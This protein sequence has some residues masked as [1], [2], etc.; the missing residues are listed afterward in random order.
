M[1]IIFTNCEYEADTIEKPQPAAENI[2]DWYKEA[3]SYLGAPRV[4][5][6]TGD[7]TATVKKCMPL[8]DMLTAGYII[9]TH[10]DIFVQQI[11]GETIYQWSG[12]QAVSFQPIEQVQKHPAFANE[13]SAARFLMPWGIKTPKGYS[14]LFLPPSHRE[15]PFNVLPGIIDTD[16]YHAPTNTF[17][18][19]KNPNFMGIIP[20]GTPYAQVIPFKRE[21]WTSETG[22]AKEK[23]LSKMNVEKRGLIFYDR[24][25][26]FWWQRKEYK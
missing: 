18:T 1:K 7:A 22:G 19:L 9:T 25:K 17:F 23:R 26:K 24:Y 12:N 8:F 20:A 4:P 10:C 13:K 16:T 15:T 6:I 11:N 5:S 3:K 14:V 21:N 2:P